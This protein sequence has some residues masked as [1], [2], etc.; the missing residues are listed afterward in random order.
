[1]K[2]NQQHKA[3]VIDP[4][5]SVV[6]FDFDNTI[7]TH[8]V[9]DDMILRFSGDN[10]W[11]EL[12]N[13]WKE[14]KIGSR[15]CLEGQVKGLRITKNKLNRYLASVELDPYFKKLIE[16]FDTKKIKKVIL[17]DNFDYILKHILRRNSF[18]GLKLYSNKLRFAKD[19]LIP[20][21][22]FKSRHCAKCAHCKAKNLLA[23]ID[24]DSIIIYI[25]D[26][27]SDTCPAEYADI[28]FAKKDL[29]KYCRG[30]NLRCY[31]YGTLRDVLGLFK[32][33]LL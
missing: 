7:T 31:R 13:K 20:S 5:K 3:S 6:F 22:P 15:E 21:F 17:S 4:R 33:S 12:E 32:R 30:K 14:G 25:G 29:L 18:K 2:I 10:R 16:F 19:R 9:F 27:K 23:N 26:G 28:I 8:D 1:M 11:L 24:K